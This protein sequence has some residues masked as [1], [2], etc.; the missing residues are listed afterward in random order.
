MT[1]SVGNVPTVVSELCISDESSK[2][3]KCDDDGGRGGVVRES[4]SGFA[5]EVLPRSGI[6]EL[7]STKAGR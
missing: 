4:K 5:R 7:P 2:G 6:S 3:E 1:P